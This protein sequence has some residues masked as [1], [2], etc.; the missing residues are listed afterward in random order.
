MTEPGR[1]VC[2]EGEDV[3][4]CRTC[5]LT[6]EM[7]ASFIVVDGLNGALLAFALAAE[8]TWV[9]ILVL[10]TSKG[11]VITPARPPA[12]APVRSSNGV[13]ISLLCFHCLAQVCACS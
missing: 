13:P 7:G 6:E 4:I 10:T 2:V 8:L 12:A 1:G 9:W 5:C 11:H 3:E